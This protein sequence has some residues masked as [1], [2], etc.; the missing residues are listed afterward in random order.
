MFITP[1][2]LAKTFYEIITS[3]IIIIA[4][5]PTSPI[6]ITLTKDAFTR[7]QFKIFEFYK[8]TTEYRDI[9]DLIIK[10]RTC[11]YFTIA[12]TNITYIYI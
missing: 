7:Y 11:I 1:I 4:T 8:K 12:A 10:V 9:L 5:T 6:I 2:K 3:I